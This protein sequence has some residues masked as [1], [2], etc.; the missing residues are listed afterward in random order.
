MDCNSLYHPTLTFYMWLLSFSPPT[1]SLS[2][3]NVETSSNL[4]F[5]KETRT[6]KV[7]AEFLSS[8]TKC[9]QER[10]KKKEEGKVLFYV[11]T[12]SSGKSAPRFHFEKINIME[13]GIRHK[14][15]FPFTSDPAGSGKC[16]CYSALKTS[17]RCPRRT[18]TRRGDRN[19]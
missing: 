11:F 1:F 4:A 9:P 3:N 15:N 17:G 5:Q 19:R 18:E 10:K 14:Y 13:S 8:V 12:I 16:S 2:A 6:H 7:S